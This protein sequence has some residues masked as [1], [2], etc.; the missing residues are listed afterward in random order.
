M[1]SMMAEDPQSDSENNQVPS[2]A[3]VGELGEAIESV[4][5]HRVGKRGATG[6]STKFWAVR[7]AGDP[8]LGL[9]SSQTEQ[10]F[11]VKWR[12]RSHI[13]NTWESQSSLGAMEELGGCRKLQNYQKKLSQQ[14]NW[15]RTASL[16]EVEYQEI[17]LQRDRQIRASYTDIQRIFAE[18]RRTDTVQYFVKWTNLHYEDAT[19]EEESTIKAH[20]GEALTDFKARKENTNSYPSNFQECMKN[21]PTVFRPL[22]CQPSFLGSDSQRLRDYQ[23]VGLNFLLSGFHKRAGLILA[24]E[25]VGLVTSPRSSR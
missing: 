12:G 5:D 19:W 2:D 9:E 25:M 11:L 3:A 24:D 15:R 6:P 23:L 1:T 8:N 22:R 18:R 13:N 14:N 4:L 17:E 16:D 7:E 21:D 20:Y 10:Q